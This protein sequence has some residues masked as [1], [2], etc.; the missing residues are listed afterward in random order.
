MSQWDAPYISTDVVR[1]QPPQGVEPIDAFRLT[2]GETIRPGR[3]RF[4]LDH[5]LVIK[6]PERFRPIAGCSERTRDTFGEMVA[7]AKRQTGR[8]R[9]GTPA[10]G[11]QLRV[12]RAPRPLKLP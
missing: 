7:R 5:E 6:H 3:D 4:S 12:P 9:T 10:P 1:R 11:G 2:N 8:T